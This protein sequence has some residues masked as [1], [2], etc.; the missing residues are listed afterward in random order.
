MTKEEIK[1]YELLKKKNDLEV[2]A[3]Q[4]WERLDNEV[5]CRKLPSHAIPLQIRLEEFGARFDRKDYSAGKMV[6]REMPNGKS[7]VCIVVYLNPYQK[8]EDVKEA[9]RHELIHLALMMTGLKHDDCSAVFKVLCDYYDARFYKVLIGLEEKLYNRTKG[10]MDL[11]LG[12]LKN[13]TFVAAD[14]QAGLMIKA[15]GDAKITEINQIDSVVEK[16]ENI[17]NES[18]TIIDSQSKV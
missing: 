1:E 15:I 14:R 13:N 17:L 2:Y 12:F 3:M 16:L 10:L 18:Q 8:I 6:D 5:F 9:I 4:F 7:Y 11:G